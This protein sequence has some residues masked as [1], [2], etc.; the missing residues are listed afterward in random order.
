[1]VIFFFLNAAISAFNAWSVGKVWLE[2]HEVNWFGKIQIYSGAIMSAAGFIWCILVLEVEGLLL[3]RSHPI[4]GKQLHFVNDLVAKMPAAF[5]GQ[6]FALGYLVIIIPILGS[7]LAI[8][9]QSWAIAWRRRQFSDIAVAGYNTFAQVYN[10]VQF[11]NVLPDVLSSVGDLFSGGD[12]D[13]EGGW[14]IYAVALVFLAIVGGIG[15]TILIIRR[16]AGS[17]RTAMAA[18]FQ[19]R[20]DELSREGVVVPGAKSPQR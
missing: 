9:A 5:P 10:L 20:V 11:I 14:W 18:R 3:L 15:L 6:V 7:G 19:A 1:M 16:S 2:R 12:D 13:D 8:T 17:H 4:P